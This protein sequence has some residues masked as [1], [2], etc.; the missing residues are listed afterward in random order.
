LGRGR[1]WPELCAEEYEERELA[2]FSFE[3]RERTKEEEREL[4][5]FPILPFQTCAAPDTTKYCVGP[6]CF[7]NLHTQPG[8][9][10]GMRNFR[11]I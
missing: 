10:R 8:D 1:P 7:P 5:T 11:V 9:R 2:T 4:G 6:S 3:E